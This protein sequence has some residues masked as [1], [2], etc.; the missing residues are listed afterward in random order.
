MEV[1]DA[2][3]RSVLA[4]LQAL[5]RD[6]LYYSLSFSDLSTRLALRAASRHWCKLI[7]GSITDFVVYED[8]PPAF[9]R[10]LGNLPNLKR[11]E[12]HAALEGADGKASTRALK[13]LTRLEAL[14]MTRCG[15]RAAISLIKK[16][17]HL[18]ELVLESN[19]CSDNLRPMPRLLMHM[20]S[21]QT[22][23]LD[24]TPRHGGVC[25]FTSPVLGS[26]LTSLNLSPST[27][28]CSED[29]LPNL[30]HLYS[31]GASDS[32]L[33][34]FAYSSLRHL[35]IGVLPLALLRIPRLPQ[36]ETLVLRG[37]SPLAGANAEALAALSGWFASSPHL[38]LLHLPSMDRNTPQAQ[39]QQVWHAMCSSLTN[40]TSLAWREW[41]VTDRDVEALPQ[42]QTLRRL[43][44]ANQA[45]LD[46][47]VAA[48]KIETQAAVSAR[49]IAWLLALKEGFGVV[50]EGWQPVVMSHTSL[51]NA[52]KQHWSRRCE[53][54][55]S[56][57]VI[58]ARVFATGVPCKARL[59][60]AEDMDEADDSSYCT[61]DSGSEED[62]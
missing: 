16:M 45:T 58:G 4:R 10:F 56:N 1:T 59:A 6:L 38:R 46:L 21:L 34:S 13:T 55:T 50:G 9:Y 8:L 49:V 57:P 47:L 18:R 14:T 33:T 5:P 43:D 61:N 26:S 62:E 44:C 36:L 40:L 54:I 39:A 3:D 23:S 42:L 32:L 12:L 48:T 17:P 60:G 27:V 15:C 7:D 52:L 53:E 37:A 28:A 2:K 24:H 20:T 11:L 41:P 35:E 25:P 51:A 22:L 29:G 31:E 30:V 19:Y